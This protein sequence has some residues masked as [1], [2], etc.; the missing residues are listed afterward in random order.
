MGNEVK[1]TK[2]ERETIFRIDDDS[3]E[4]EAY[5]CI[6]KDMKRLEK[7]GWSVK[8]IQYY[9]DGTVMTMTFSAP[10]YALSIG[11]AKRKTKTFT[12]EQRQAASER[13]KKLKIDLEENKTGEDNPHEELVQNM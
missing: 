6:S 12:A 11:K 2:E 5:T 3:N 8:H 9:Y 4:W 10:R 7:Q 1:L 13:M